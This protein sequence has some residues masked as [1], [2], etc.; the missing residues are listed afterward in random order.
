M[1]LPLRVRVFLGKAQRQAEIF[2]VN[3]QISEPE[4]PDIS[5]A[6]QGLR[7]TVALNDNQIISLQSRDEFLK[8]LLVQVFGE[9]LGA[10]SIPSLPVQ[11]V[12]DAQHA[13]FY[14][15][16]PSTALA[17]YVDPPQHVSR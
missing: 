14:L 13:S 6:G 12:K 7:V 17:A 15:G 16:H 9:N 10:V 2:C 3:V 8:P 5:V 1:G 11:V 4:D